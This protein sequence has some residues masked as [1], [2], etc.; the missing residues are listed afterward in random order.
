MLSL[1][2]KERL[3]QEIA[4][5]VKFISEGRQFFFEKTGEGLQSPDDY[6][7]HWICKELVADHPEMQQL[8][9]NIQLLYIK[10]SSY[11]AEVGSS[12]DERSLAKPRNAFA[13]HMTDI[14][15]SGRVKYNFFVHKFSQNFKMIMFLFYE[16]SP[17]GPAESEKEP[18]AL[19]VEL[20]EDINR[21]LETWSGKPK[22]E[23]LG[24][25]EL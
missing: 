1:S 20:F 6:L 25:I 12:P 24:D 18:V 2:N 5:L 22:G 10:L 9:L 17:E 3:E 16:T 7:N 8:L 19:E 14:I 23:I 11:Y 21:F 13:H 15:F 4:C